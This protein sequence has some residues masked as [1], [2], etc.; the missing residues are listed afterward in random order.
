MTVTPPP[1]IVG[2]LLPLRVETKFSPPQGLAG[3]LLRVRVIPD[4]PSVDG[5]DPLASD[6]ELDSV[7]SLWQ[8]C[9]GDLSTGQGIVEWRAFCARHGAGRAAWLARTFPPVGSGGE[10]TVNR[11][12]QVRTDPRIADLAGLPPTI[13]LWLA[14]RGCRTGVGRHPHPRPRVASFGPARPHFRRVALVVVIRHRRAGRTGHRDRSGQ[15]R[16]RHRRSLRG[17]YRRRRPGA[18]V[19]GSS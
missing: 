11:P 2:V 10:I 17:R 6:V 9:S 5:H 13:E 19:R 15:S 18:A 12:A 1:P 7:T 14:R 3:W 16:G 8:N 4:V